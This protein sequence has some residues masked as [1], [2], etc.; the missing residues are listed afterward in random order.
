MRVVFS[1]KTI[2]RAAVVGV[3]AAG[4]VVAGVSSPASADPCGASSYTSGTTRYVGYRNCGS[5]DIWKHGEI[6]GI[7]QGCFIVPG[8]GSKTLAKDPRGKNKSWGVGDCVW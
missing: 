4:A 8:G 1:R 5:N 6:G 3:I 7:S 2:A